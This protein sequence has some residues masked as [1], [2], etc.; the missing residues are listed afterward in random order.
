[1]EINCFCEGQGVEKTFSAVSS[2]MVLRFW[3][4]EDGGRDVNSTIINIMILIIII[5]LFYSTFHLRDLQ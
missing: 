1:M 5:I 2:G 3:L 4:E